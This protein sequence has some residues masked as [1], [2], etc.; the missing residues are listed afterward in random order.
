MKTATIE[1]HP[2]HGKCG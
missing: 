2:K 1:L